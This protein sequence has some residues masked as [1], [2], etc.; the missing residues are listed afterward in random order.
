MSCVLLL[1]LLLLSS[2]VALSRG[3]LCTRANYRDVLL[4]FV[5][6]FNR[7]LWYQVR[8]THAGGAQLLVGASTA[9][10]LRNVLSVAELECIAKQVQWSLD[11]D[12]DDVEFDASNS[13]LVSV[14][15]SATS[16]ELLQPVKLAFTA[17]E[18]FTFA[19]DLTQKCRIVLHEMAWSAL[20]PDVLLLNALLDP[21]IKD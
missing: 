17:Q 5:T 19:K 7:A 9:P 3:Q 11:F 15:H 2:L 4:D 14:R 6:S 8:N 13:A 10:H 16:L 20:N 12:I 1:L 18:R 21:C